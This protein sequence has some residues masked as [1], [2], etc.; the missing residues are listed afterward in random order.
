[1]EKLYIERFTAE[2]LVSQVENI[3]SKKNNL[4]YTF[5]TI[6]LPKKIHELSLENAIN[7]LEKL[8]STRAYLTCA[9]LLERHIK[10]KTEDINHSVD[11][12]GK[13]THDAISFYSMAAKNPAIEP[14][15]SSLLWDLKLNSKMKSVKCRL[16]EY[17]LYNPKMSGNINSKHKNISIPLANEARLFR[18]PRPSIKKQ[19][20][21]NNPENSL[22]LVLTNFNK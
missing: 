16:S 5:D 14:I 19:V 4:K 17:D 12:W 10:N 2:Q 8:N 15:V 20:N 11:H 3:I 1:M 21:S 18:L 22:D 9:L 7:I 13:R 6:K